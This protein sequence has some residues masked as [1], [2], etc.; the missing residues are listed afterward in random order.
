MPSHAT[1]WE[2]VLLPKAYKA[3]LR[4]Q[5]QTRVYYRHILEY[6]SGAGVTRPQL[7]ACGPNSYFP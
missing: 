3:A 5:I 4:C 6:N 7:F 2:H 1:D